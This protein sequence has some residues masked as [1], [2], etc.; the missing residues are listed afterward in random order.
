MGLGRPVERVRER[1]DLV[2][3]VRGPMGIA[4]AAADPERVRGQAAE[5]PRQPAG[6]DDPARR[7][8]G[9]AEETQAQRPLGQGGHG[10]R[11]VALGHADEDPPRGLPHHER[12]GPPQEALALVVHREGRLVLRVGVPRHPADERR[13][14]APRAG[15][16]PVARADHDLAAARRRE[17]LAARGDPE[18]VEELRQ[19]VQREVHR[20]DA[21]HRA[22]R[23]EQRGD[24]ADPQAPARVELVGLGPR[25]RALALGQTEVRPLV[26]AVPVIVRAPDR[27]AAAIREHAVLQEVDSRAHRPAA[28]DV[29]LLRRVPPRADEAVVAAAVAR[30]G[31]VWVRAERGQRE[32]L[33]GVGGSRVEQ[34][35]AHELGAEPGGGLRVPEETLDVRRREPARARHGAVQELLREGALLLPGQGAEHRTRE[36]GETDGQADQRE[37]EGQPPPKRTDQPR[38]RPA[39]VRG[40]RGPTGA[41]RLGQ[42]PVDQRAH[43]APPR[44]SSE[45]RSVPDGSHPSVTIEVIIVITKSTRARPG[46]SLSRCSTSPS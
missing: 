12:H 7:D 4:T 42:Q 41:E 43:D 1:A 25:H 40:P 6:G 21:A 46:A 5:R 30:P 2:P 39:A 9:E 20:E 37:R 8:E 13:A 17:H 18:A 11:V 38:A 23:V 45:A 27:L 33:E 15:L 3:R 10:L 36:D 44:A 32:P 24:A 28:V 19:G 34:P 35:L 31:E 16:D 29:D 26:R 22:G 14:Q